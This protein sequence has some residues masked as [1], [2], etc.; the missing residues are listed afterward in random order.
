MAIKNTINLQ[1][2]SDTEMNDF[3]ITNVTQQND[4][5]GTVST[6]SLIVPQYGDVGLTGT[7]T[8]SKNNELSN[9]TLKFRAK[10]KFSGETITT[11]YLTI[12]QDKHPNKYSTGVVEM[13]TSDGRV[14]SG[15]T[16]IFSESGGRF[17]IRA[18]AI[19]DE[20]GDVLSNISYFRFFC[21]STTF[22]NKIHVFEANGYAQAQ[23]KVS[24]NA[25]LKKRSSD[26]GIVFNDKNGSSWFQ[27]VTI[28]QDEHVKRITDVV[29]NYSPLN[30]G[31]AGGNILINCSYKEDGKVMEL[32]G[33]SVVNISGFTANYYYL[34]DSGATRTM[35]INENTDETPNGAPT[36]LMRL[37]AIHPVTNNNI[38]GD[39]IQQ[40]SR[41]SSSY[42]FTFSDGTTNKI[43]EDIIPSSGDYFQCYV[44][45]KNGFK[46]VNFTPSSDV[47]WIE[48]GEVSNRSFMVNILENKD[49]KA[50]NGI[51]KVVQDDSP[52]PPLTYQI[53]QKGENKY[54]I[55]NFD[56]MII[57]V[58]FD[59]LSG[60]DLDLFL[61]APDMPEKYQQFKLAGSG[62][63]KI[64]KEELL[65]NKLYD[66]TDIGDE[67]N[68]VLRWCGD[69]NGFGGESYVV[70]PK[71]FLT[72]DFIKA[73]IGK[74]KTYFDI[75]LYG[76]FHTEYSNLAT[77]TMEAYQSDGTSDSNPQLLNKKN[78]LFFY[79]GKNARQISRIWKNA[80]VRNPG[81]EEE[82]WLSNY[83]KIATFRYMYRTGV[84]EFQQND[85]VVV[86]PTEEDK[87]IVVEG[88]PQFDNTIVE[89]GN[90]DLINDY[91]FG[92]VF[93]NYTKEW[94][95]F[96]AL[97]KDKLARFNFNESEPHETVKAHLHYDQTKYS[98]TKVAIGDCN[99]SITT[100]EWAKDGSYLLNKPWSVSGNQ[101]EDDKL[102]LYFEA[103]DKNE[104]DDYG[105]V[106]KDT[107]H[108]QE[109]TSSDAIPLTELK[110][111]FTDTERGIIVPFTIE[112]ASTSTFTNRKIKWKRHVP[113]TSSCTFKMTKLEYDT[114]L[115]ALSGINAY[116]STPVILSWPGMDELIYNPNA[117]N[118]N[119]AFMW[120][121]PNPDYT[122]Y[123]INLIVSAWGN[124]NTHTKVE[125]AQTNAP[126]R[127]NTYV[128]YEDSPFDG[129]NGF[130]AESTYIIKLN[131]QT[132]GGEYV[133]LK[134]TCY[135][136]MN[137][138]KSLFKYTKKTLDTF[139]LEFG[140][141]ANT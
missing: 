87:E 136:K 114:S 10:A 93:E 107:R 39:L 24:P 84:W 62:A 71:T 34:P 23:Y 110:G 85:G 117:Q 17:T 15:D 74:N 96:F 78:N 109:L 94:V 130:M 81:K 116:A 113:E 122:L 7:I 21:T 43:T 141:Y 66:F 108:F 2:Y 123:T 64:L 91:L 76:Y 120:K 13:F 28:K 37:Q 70:S 73:E 139:V 88:M 19:Q 40:E 55:P 140:I 35:T 126:S 133:H 4:S 61:Y 63:T 101:E 129:P 58:G 131:L 86:Y 36:K 99:S 60:K 57:K 30:I 49:E 16:I 5:G 1:V 134:V 106:E 124:D 105:E 128:E 112:S 3:E 53:S 31:H 6:M 51:I 9:H 72:S 12:V 47:N 132:T 46:L 121:N 11:P 75:H 89:A 44:I 127:P 111:E 95:Q 118:C 92:Y 52:M 18:K 135:D 25:S 33:V 38:V 104:S 26:I 100:I 20:T 8:A 102:Y 82:Y 48:V 67:K 42:I 115:S 69:N 83:T 27:Y 41:K 97:G 137:N 125:Y 14:V 45:S 77:I 98:I 22:I 65:P 90:Q 56:Y 103:I 32:S 138:N 54:Q 29:F 79:P 119:L 80:Y 59:I 68:N 50:R